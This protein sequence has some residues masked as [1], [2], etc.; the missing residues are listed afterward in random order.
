MPSI[1]FLWEKYKEGV[2]RK[3]LLRQGFLLLH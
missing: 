2:K 1:F 3:T